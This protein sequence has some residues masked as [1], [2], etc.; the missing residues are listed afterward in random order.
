MRIEGVDVFKV[1]KGEFFEVEHG[2]VDLVERSVRFTKKILKVR[3][4]WHISRIMPDL[5]DLM[6][7]PVLDCSFPKVG[8]CVGNPCFVCCI[9]L[10]VSHE[11]EEYLVKECLEFASVSIVDLRLLD[12]DSSSLWLGI[13]DCE[14]LRSTW[15]ASSWSSS[16]WST[17]TWSATSWLTT[18][19]SSTWAW[20]IATSISSS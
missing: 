19:R 6:C 3:P 9:L 8:Q 13:G 14:V 10:G 18:S 7:L 15:V 2:I 16:T 4:A 12:L 17:S 11:Y 1:F 5:G 20:Y